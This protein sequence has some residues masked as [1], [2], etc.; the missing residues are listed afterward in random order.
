MRL[1]LSRGQ[2]KIL[3]PCISIADDVYFLPMSSDCLHLDG[4]LLDC[5]IG[6]TPAERRRPRRLLASVA[7]TCDLARA[8]R[9]DCLA[10]TVDYAALATRLRAVARSR[11][12]VLLESLARRLAEECL[13]E[14]R[15]SEVRVLLAKPRPCR[16]LARAAVEITRRRRPHRPEG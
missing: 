7:L 9:S 8:G 6:A 13:A 1:P 14:R 10:D 16:Y 12:W 3:H 11:D 15:I 4:L 2:R 5:R